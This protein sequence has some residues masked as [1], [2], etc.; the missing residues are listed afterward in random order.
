MVEKKR[1]KSRLLVLDL[2]F[3]LMSLHKLD[4]VHVL[5]IKVTTTCAA[6]DERAFR[7]SPE[8]NNGARGQQQTHIVRSAAARMAGWVVAGC[9]STVERPRYCP[10]T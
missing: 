8:A 9:V 3:Q 7:R 2:L 5:K 10:I 6:V 1:K 4:K